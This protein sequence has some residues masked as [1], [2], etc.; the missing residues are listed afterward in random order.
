MLALAVIALLA[1]DY[2]RTNMEAISQY[3]AFGFTITF[4][5]CQK[6]VGYGFTFFV[7]FHNWH[8]FLLQEL[9]KKPPQAVLPT[10]VDE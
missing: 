8:I 2:S 6:L 9:L 7:L 3:F 1:A 5:D 10:E 4:A